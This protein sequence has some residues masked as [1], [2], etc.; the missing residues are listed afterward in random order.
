M[1]LY[2]LVLYFTP[3]PTGTGH[4]HLL[5]IYASRSA[6]A[7]GAQLDADHN[8]PYGDELIPLRWDG[9]DGHYVDGSLH[10]VYQIVE[11]ELN[12]DY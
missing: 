10:W 1:K 12:E 4:I 5:G 6:A 7:S 11:R 2:A 3:T 8:T 9:D